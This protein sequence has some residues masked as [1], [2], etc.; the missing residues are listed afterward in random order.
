MYTVDLFIR[1]HY[2]PCALKPVDTYHEGVFKCHDAHKLAFIYCRHGIKESHVVKVGHPGIRIALSGSVDGEI[3]NAKRREVLEK[4]RSLAR[5]YPL[6]RQRRLY[7]EAG[8]RYGWPLHRDTQG[9]VRGT[10]S[11]GTYQQIPFITFK[12]SAIDLFHLTRYQ[13]IVG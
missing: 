1:F 8:C 5:L 7:Y 13:R 10:P 4:V 2:H 3:C 12:K 6:V 9:G 11:A